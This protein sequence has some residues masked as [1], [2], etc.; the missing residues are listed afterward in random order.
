M[1]VALDSCSMGNLLQCRET[2][3]G[4]KIRK[5]IKEDFRGEVGLALRTFK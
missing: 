2:E 1:G 4:Q 5:V 3:V